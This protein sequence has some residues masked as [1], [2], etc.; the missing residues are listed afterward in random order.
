MNQ[1]ASHVFSASTYMIILFSVSFI[2]VQL[3]PHIFVFYHLFHFRH[4]FYFI[5]PFC[6]ESFKFIF[7][8]SI[9]LIPNEKIIKLK[10][11]HIVKFAILHHFSNC[12]SDGCFYICSV[13]VCYLSVNTK[14]H[15]CFQSMLICSHK[16]CH[17]N[18]HFAV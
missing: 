2:K 13:F 14:H 12:L 15:G 4:S 7:I 3:Y 9:A 1:N 5:I 10:E 16:T 11:I 6:I 18:L 17:L 8:I